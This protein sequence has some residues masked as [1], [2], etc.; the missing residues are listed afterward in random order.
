MTFL[1]VA[2]PKEI[3]EYLKKLETQREA[4]QDEII[5][6]VYFMSGLDWNSAWATSPML[7]QKIIKMIIKNKKAEMGDT[8]QQM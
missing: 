4:I 7:R 8:S 5:E 2:E 3:T 1:S 6:I